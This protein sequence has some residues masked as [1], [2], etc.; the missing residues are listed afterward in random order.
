MSIAGFG[1]CSCLVP[2]SMDCHCH[3]LNDVDRGKGSLLFIAEEN[4]SMKQ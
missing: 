3:A 1:D 2:E 4:T